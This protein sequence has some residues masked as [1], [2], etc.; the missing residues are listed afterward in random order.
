MLKVRIIHDTNYLNMEVKAN[1]FLSDAGLTREQL[2]SLK[3]NIDD[4]GSLVFVYE[5]PPEPKTNMESILHE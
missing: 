3:Y 4:H 1:Q 5:V 2:V